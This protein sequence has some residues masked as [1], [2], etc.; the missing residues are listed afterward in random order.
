MWNICSAK[1]KS[2][3]GKGRFFNKPTSN[4][5]TVDRLYSLMPKFFTLII[6]LGLSFPGFSQN[7][8]I[9]GKVADSTIKQG[10]ADATISVV[11]PKDSTPVS[12]TI[13]DKNGAFEIKNL[14]S[15]RYRVLVSY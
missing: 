6:I 2:L 11:N 8:V 14:D 1:C 13:S 12:Y 9:K 10:L 5:F 15:G 4:L 3:A 7:G